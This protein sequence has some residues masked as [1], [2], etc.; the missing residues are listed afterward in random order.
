M[1]EERRD[2]SRYRIAGLKSVAEDLELVA[3]GF[4]ALSTEVN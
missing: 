2:C 3:G 4:T 1:Q